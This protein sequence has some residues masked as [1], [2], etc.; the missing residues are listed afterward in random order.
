MLRLHQSSFQSAIA[1]TRLR[2]LVTAQAR[3]L[4][5]L[6]PSTLDEGFRLTPARLR[7]PFDS[8]P[9]YQRV[10]AWYLPSDVLDRI[11]PRLR[12]FGDEAVSDQIHEWISNAKTQQPYIKTRDLFNNR[13][14]YDRLVT[15]R[16]WKKLGRWG[17]SNG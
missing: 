14:P 9:A 17:I 11:A 6:K 12:A 10:L 8:D 5:S 4:S 16:G 3:L 2:P 1:L 15:S 13:Y 7:N